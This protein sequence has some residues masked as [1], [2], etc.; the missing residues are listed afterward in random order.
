M[1]SLQVVDQFLRSP[2]SPGER[3]ENFWNM[4]LHRQCVSAAQTRLAGRHVRKTIVQL[5]RSAGL[6][7]LLSVE[8][9]PK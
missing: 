9:L 1:A 6:R 2:E 4:P 7:I 8:S 3:T 5:I